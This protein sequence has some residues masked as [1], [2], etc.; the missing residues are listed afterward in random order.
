MSDFLPLRG[1]VYPRLI[2]GGEADY[3]VFRDVFYG[4]LIVTLI[5][6]AITLGWGASL[7]IRDRIVRRLAG[8]R[9][10]RNVVYLARGLIFRRFCLRSSYAR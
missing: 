9:M 2:A 3:L 10:L 8:Y 6:V 4:L 7:L 1:L 5:L